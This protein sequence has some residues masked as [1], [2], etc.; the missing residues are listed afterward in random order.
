MKWFTPFGVYI[1]CAYAHIHNMCTRKT[2]R[3]TLVHCFFHYLFF[4]FSCP[5]YH[6]DILLSVVVIRSYSSLFL[7]LFVIFLFFFLYTPILY[8]QLVCFV[9]CLYAFTFVQFNSLRQREIIVVYATLQFFFAAS[10]S[11][12]TYS[13]SATNFHFLQGT[14]M[15]TETETCR[16]LKRKRWNS[17]TKKKIE[18]NTK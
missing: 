3:Y 17:Q 7:T 13:I 10:V 4:A 6:E 8:H 11:T 1:R 12:S 18:A 15:A 9:Y 2:L 5:L 16:I 14:L